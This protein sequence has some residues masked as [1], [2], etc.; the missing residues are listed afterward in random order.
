[1]ERKPVLEYIILIVVLIAAGVLFLQIKNQEINLCR[2]IFNGLTNRV[3][4]AEKFIDWENL[5]ALDVDVGAFYTRL[6]DEKDKGGYR[7]EFIRNFSVGFAKAGGRLNLFTNWRIWYRD[8]NKVI[9]AA[10]YS[11]YNKTIL[12]TLSKFGKIKLTSIQW[13]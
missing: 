5:K 3:Y 12:F 6:A 1:M 8:S 11:G 4:A 7:K 2:Y 13:R 9:V 10:D